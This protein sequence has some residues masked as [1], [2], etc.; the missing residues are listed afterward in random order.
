[1]SVLRVNFV[2]FPISPR[3]SAA[4]VAHL[5][6][7]VGVDHVL[8]G[9]EVAMQDLM[10]GALQQLKSLFPSQE[11]PTFSPVF[12]FEDLY[13]PCNEDAHTL[14]LD[15]LPLTSV[16]L[17]DTVYYLHSSGSTNFPKPIALSHLRWIQAAQVPWFGDLD[18]TDK[19]L[20]FHLMP[21]SHGMGTS[22]P[23]WTASTGLVVAAFEPKVP[24][25]L[26]TPENVFEASRLTSCD[27]LLC[28]PAFAE[29]WSRR[30]DYVQWLASRSG[31]IYGGGPLNHKTGEYLTAQGVSIF[32]MY[33]MTEV[34]TLT[35]LIPSKTTNEEWDHFCFSNQ[36]KCHWKPHGDNLFELI[37]MDNP[38][39]SPGVFN[40]EVDGVRSYATSDLFIPH[41]TK[42]GCWQI[43]GRVDDQIIHSTGEKTNPGPL[44]S[45]LNQ[46]PHVAAAV[47]FGQGRF[48]AGVLIEPKPTFRFDP[49]D[50]VKLAEFRNSIWPTV[51]QA[52]EHAP[53]HSRIFKE[54][55]LIASPTKPFTYTMKGTARRQAVL[56][57]YSDEISELYDIFDE[58]TQSNIPLPTFWDMA[59]TTTFVRAVVNSVLTHA[60]EDDED[61]FQHGGDSLQA[62]W[63]RNSLLRALRD[64]AE[65]DSRT[66][67]HNFVYDHPTI[68]RLS[69]Y[70]FSLAVGGMSPEEPDD[71][72]RKAVMA[73]LVKKYS[74][75]MSAQLRR[76]D[77]SEGAAK[78]V[79][80]TGSTGSLGSYVLS[81]LIEHPDVSHVYA[82]IRR[83][84]VDVHQRQKVALENRGLDAT[85]ILQSEKVTL[86][87]ADLAQEVLGVNDSVFDVISNTVTHIIDIAWRVDFNLSVSSFQ[88]NLKGMRNMINLAIRRD[89]HYVFAST[90][91]VCRNAS[92]G[93]EEQ[94]SADAALGN[95]YSE[96]KWVAEEIICASTPAG[97]RASIVR[98]GQLSGGPSGAWS[99]REWFPSLVEASSHF[100]MVPDDDG[101]VSWVPLRAAGQAMV[102]FLNSPSDAENPRFLHLVH[103]RPVP[104]R[105]I[106]QILVKELDASLVSS[107]DWLYALE[108]VVQ[109]RTQH[110]NALVL[111]PFFKAVLS[112]SKEKAKEA[113]GANRLSTVRSQA[114]S[115]HLQI[116][117]LLEEKDVLMWL[118]YWKRQGVLSD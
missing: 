26:P 64:S 35:P 34:N 94:V 28:V 77:G 48:H 39:C 99:A 2:A 21:M 63:I 36:V 33:G 3:N 57:V 45:I 112:E 4:A 58:T 97:L 30:P 95:G 6:G 65:L 22:L 110:L 31:L 8:V 27:V 79:L 59:S 98:V 7:T 102:D 38:H 115:R 101:V 72:A 81:R 49:S 52:N 107:K 114:T 113:F 90:V 53:Q 96:S 5:L 60:I 16:D 100:K 75:E 23:A 118:E 86:L 14:Q 46:D 25:I 32:S 43:H 18:W 67:T 62:T 74:Q 51:E 55:V 41:P 84:T 20:S 13:V 70:V 104:W 80:L 12:I 47:M 93:H 40:T 56:R 66:V 37:V 50:K 1:M 69:T 92:H 19:V 109:G 17:D 76:S 73:D 9:R 61:I 87:E 29:A 89:A 44:E 105:M 103:P 111:L 91:A 88:T 24:A 106:A 116:L 10:T 83:G 82:L 68:E 78:I 108:G 11:P 85:A 42:P 15:E 54:M 117:D 71:S